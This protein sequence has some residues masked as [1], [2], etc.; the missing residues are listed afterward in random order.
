L[1]SCDKAMHES[2]D[3]FCKFIA[4]FMFQLQ[5]VPEDL[6][7]DIVSGEDFISVTLKNLFDCLDDEKL[8]S[9]LIE[10]C[11]SSQVVSFQSAI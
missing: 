2:P 10:K 1:C 6:F 5:Q 9:K 8:N 4:T 3:F 7:V 11:D